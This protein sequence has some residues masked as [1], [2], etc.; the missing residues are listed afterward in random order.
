MNAFIKMRSHNVVA[1]AVSCAPGF[2]SSSVQMFFSL[3]G[4]KVSGKKL[5]GWPPKIVWCQIE[6]KLTLTQPRVKTSLTKEHSGEKC[7]FSHVQGTDE[8]W[9]DREPW[10]FWAYLDGKLVPRWRWGSRAHACTPERTSPG[11]CV[12][13]EPPKEAETVTKG[14]GLVKQKKTTISKPS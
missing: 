4:C 12:R 6:I 3:P 10:H 7:F 13:W 2:N 1:R 8:S 5:R 9:W 14:S 11:R